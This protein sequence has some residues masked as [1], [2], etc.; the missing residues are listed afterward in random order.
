[1]V[2]WRLLSYT[3]GGIPQV[4]LQLLYVGWIHVALSLLDIQAAKAMVEIS[5]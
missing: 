4:P 2:T 1:M 3:G 5:R